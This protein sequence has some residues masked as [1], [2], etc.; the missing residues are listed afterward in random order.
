MDDNTQLGDAHVLER[1]VMAME[2]D[3]LS[4]HIILRY[5][6]LAV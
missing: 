3:L 5:T 6:G 4:R 2:Q 1:L